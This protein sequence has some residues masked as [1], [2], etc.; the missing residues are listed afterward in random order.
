MA[1]VLFYRGYRIE[2]IDYSDLFRVWDPKYP[3]QT[4]AYH[5][6]LQEA[7]NGIDEQGIYNDIY[8]EDL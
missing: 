7:Y 5:H 1:T 4:V 6:T 2:Y 3:S 8:E